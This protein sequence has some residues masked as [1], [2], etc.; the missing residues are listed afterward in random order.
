MTLLWATD[1]SYFAL[2]GSAVQMDCGVCIDMYSLVVCGS[3]ND[4]REMSR[5]DGKGPASRCKLIHQLQG[6]QARCDLIC[7]KSAVNSQPA[8]ARVQCVLSLC[9]L[10]FH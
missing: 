7:V 10:M 1:Q 8:A 6:T 2:Y 5:W 4:L 3:A 9:A